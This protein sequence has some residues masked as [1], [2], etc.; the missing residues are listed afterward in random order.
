[1]EP[2]HI[3]KS[4]TRVM[5]HYSAHPENG[6]SEDKPAKAVLQSGLRIRVEGPD[7][8]A[9]TTDMPTPLGGE[10]SAPSPGWLRRAAQSGIILQSLEVT[11]GSV[12]DDRGMLG[13]AQDVPAGPG[14]SWARVVVS[15]KGTPPERLREVVAWAEQ[16][17]PVTDALCRA[18]PHKLQVEVA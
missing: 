16:H 11:I 3:R 14:E 2:E 10:G 17:S 13:V 18:V 4:V 1:M 12:S 15:A 9:I 7:S 5:E 8:W 6:L